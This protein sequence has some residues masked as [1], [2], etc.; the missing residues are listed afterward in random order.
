MP[1]DSY[2]RVLKGKKVGEFGPSW[3]IYIYIYMAKASFSA[4][5][6]VKLWLK[7]GEKVHFSAK[8]ARPILVFLF[9]SSLFP[10]L[11]QNG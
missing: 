2:D 4:Y 5:V 6:L 7:I 3:H 10:F 1:Q 8:K 11:P 9:V